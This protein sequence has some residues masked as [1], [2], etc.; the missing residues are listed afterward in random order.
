MKSDPLIT[1][2]RKPA[3]LDRAALEAFAEILKERLAGG[4]QFCC[5]ISNDDHLRDLNWQ[6]RGKASPT[7]VLSFP[8]GEPAGYLGDIAISLHKARFQAKQFGHTVDTE[9]RVLLLHGILH[10]NG[11]DHETDSGEMAAVERQWREQLG[12]PAS[13]I[14]RVEQ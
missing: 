12:L 11:M 9:I 6:F 13:L 7:D 4:R 2:R 5:L 14:E 3:D 8:S 10:L 1:F